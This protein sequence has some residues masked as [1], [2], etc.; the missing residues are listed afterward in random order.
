MVASENEE[1]IQAMTSEERVQEVEELK[2]RFGEGV[3]EL[4][5]KRREA[6]LKKPGPGTERPVERLSTI[7]RGEVSAE[8]GMYTFRGRSS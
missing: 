3:V 1:K 4:M 8:T 2:E 7:T 5:R 6:R